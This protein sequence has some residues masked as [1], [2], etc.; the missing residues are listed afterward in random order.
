MSDKKVKFDEDSI[1][2]Q[3]E[4]DAEDIESRLKKGKHSLDSDEEDDD[5]GAKYDVMKEDDIE[6]QEEQTIDF[7]DDIQ[8]TPFNMRDEM[9]EGHFDRDGTFIFD[10]S[11]NI[12]DNWIENIDWVRIKESERQKAQEMI[13][14]REEAEE[15]EAPA[16]DKSAIYREML[17]ILEP[18]ESVA[19]ALRRLGKSKGKKLT[20]AQ[21]WKAKRQKTENGESADGDAEKVEQDKK[22]M[23]RLTEMADLLVQDGVMEIYEA[24][25]E[26]V[27]IWLKRADEKDGKKFA[28]PEDVDDD[29]ALDMFADNFDQQEAEKKK[30]VDS[31][32]GGGDGGKGGGGGEPQS[33]SVTETETSAAAAEE[34]DDA[35]RWEYRVE[36]TDASPILGPFSSSQMLAWAEEG[37]FKDGVFCRK[38]GTEGQFYTSNRIDFDLYI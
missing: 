3:F 25:R 37:K 29:D 17:E 16:V 14:A 32:G 4:D 34:D 1:A 7:D 19:K 33:S 2:N 18:Q 31:G 30:D 11:K 28:I 23:L 9:E 26:K 36:N 38:V 35:V 22:T 10:K 24:T 15:A 12:R 5:D 13:D 21:R 20:T 6:G 27:S 8:I